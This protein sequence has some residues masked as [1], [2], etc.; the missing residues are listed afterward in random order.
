MPISPWKLRGRHG[1]AA[2]SFAGPAVNL[3]LAGVCLVVLG[4]WIHY[5]RNASDQTY[6]NVWKFFTLGCSLNIFLM[7]FNLLPVPPLDGSRIA[8][9]F[10][11]EYRRLTEHPN[12][13]IAGIVFL[14]IV[15]SQLSTPLSSWVVPNVIHA[16]GWIAGKMP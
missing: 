9:S 16:G 3:I 5:G 11:P 10:I 1:D 15:C 14:G 13:G 8:A 2:V 7:V 6:T 4:A 12:A